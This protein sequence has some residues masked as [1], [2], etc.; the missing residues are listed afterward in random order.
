MKHAILICME[1]E[2]A[3]AFLH[4]QGVWTHYR[5]WSSRLRLYT[6][7]I[8]G[9]KRRCRQNIKSGHEKREGHAA[10]FHHDE[11]SDYKR[12]NCSA[13]AEAVLCRWNL[14]TLK[15]CEEF[16]PIDWEN[17][18]P[19]ADLP[20]HEVVSHLGQCRLSGYNRTHT[21]ARARKTIGH[22][23]GV[24]RQSSK[25]LNGERAGDIQCTVLWGG[26]RSRSKQRLLDHLMSPTFWSSVF[27]DQSRM[28][29]RVSCA[30]GIQ[31]YHSSFR[32]KQQLAHGIP[33]P[34][35]HG[36]WASSQKSEMQS[37]M[38]ASNIPFGAYLDR[39][40]TR[41]IATGSWQSPLPCFL[42]LTMI[43]LC[44]GIVMGYHSAY[45][46]VRCLLNYLSL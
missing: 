25:R 7:L 1:C 5:I 37:M 12:E 44:P 22:T 9:S 17:C 19:A 2:L 27:E 3:R 26:G 6:M 46:G 8:I 34:V 32:A 43:T 42:S 4:D 39:M 40:L 33:C 28:D 18:H 13:L 10:A 21:F 16:S 23:T 24:M 38:L 15:K 35:W 36:I 29:M 41:R 14:L 31:P 20:C 30:I 11:K 45:V